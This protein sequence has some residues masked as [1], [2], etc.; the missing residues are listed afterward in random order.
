VPKAINH[1]YPHLR[2][3]EIDIWLRFL[4]LFPNRFSLIEYDYRV[5]HGIPPPT[6]LTPNLEKMTR[7]LTRQRIDAVGQSAGLKT[8][9]EIAPNA[10]TDAL[11]QLLVYRELWNQEHPGEP[12]PGLML[13]TDMD[14]P[15]IRSVAEAQ[16]VELVIV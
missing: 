12:P 11:G 2:S 4:T 6:G 8:L 13:V 15:D 1:L 7:D 5:G 3:F 9:I 16:G 14:R 10:G